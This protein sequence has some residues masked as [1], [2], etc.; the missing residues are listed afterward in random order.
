MRLL[1]TILMHQQKRDGPEV[2]VQAKFERE[3]EE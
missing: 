1:L 2:G 3:A